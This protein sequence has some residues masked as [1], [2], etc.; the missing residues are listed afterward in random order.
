[1]LAVAAV[2][3]TGGTLLVADKAHMVLVVGITA[4]VAVAVI[5][6]T[7]ARDRIYLRCRR[8][9]GTLIISFEHVHGCACTP[10]GE[11]SPATGP[12]S[13]ESGSPQP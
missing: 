12:G 9:G 5:L 10:A 3:V 11:A 2:G 8:A 13:A 7:A 4:V 1:M 6:L